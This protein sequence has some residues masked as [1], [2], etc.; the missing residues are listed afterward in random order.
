[1]RE[2]R[3]VMIVDGAEEEKEFPTPPPSNKRAA[4][5]EEQ[6]LSPKKPRVEPVVVDWTFGV[7]IP[8]GMPIDEAYSLYCSGMAAMGC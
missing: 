5:P 4:E 7:E 2:V 8:E 3:Q 1:M 6:S